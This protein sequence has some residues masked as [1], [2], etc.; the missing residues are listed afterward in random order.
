MCNQMVDR[1]VNNFT[2]VLSKTH[3]KLLLHVIIAS[4]FHISVKQINTKISRQ[5]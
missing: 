2:C 4:K 3:G 5:N 1:G